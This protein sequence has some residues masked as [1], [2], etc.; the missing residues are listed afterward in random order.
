MAVGVLNAALDYAARGWHV[1]PLHGVVGGKCSCGKTNCNRSAG[2]HPQ[3]T[4]W[5]KKASID[6]ETIAGW[7]EKWPDA[8]I[9]VQLG[10][11]SGIIDIEYDT[12]QGQ[13]TAARLFSDCFTPSYSSGGRSTHRLFRWTSDLPNIQKI[14][15]EGLEIRIGGG[16]KGTQSVFP[17]SVHHSGSIYT[18]LPGLSPDDVDVLPIPD[19]VVALFAN[20][21]QT[22]GAGGAFTAHDKE[23]WERIGRGVSEGSRNDSLASWIGKQL[24][25]IKTE[26]LEKSESVQNV[27]RSAFAVN[28]KFEPPLEQDEVRQVFASILRRERQ[29]RITTEIESQVQPSVDEQVAKQPPRG[30]AG[31][32]KIVVIE[33]DP[34]RFE[35]HAPEFIKA[36]DGK[37]ILTSDQICNGGRIRVQA[38]EQASYALSRSFSKAWDTRLRPNEPSLYERLMSAAEHIEA[39]PEEKRFLFLA[40]M[41][42]EFIQSPKQIE[43]GDEPEKLRPCQLPNGD[44]VFLFSKLVSRM[45][46]TDLVTRP[47]VSSV[48]KRVEAGWHRHGKTRF[49]KL[50]SESQKLLQN[51]LA[52]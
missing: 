18:W 23:H 22:L 40:E 29:Q 35:L 9:G 24:S 41:I 15:A 25:D 50:S 39:P 7:F 44:I 42:A 38:A 16:D 13:K 12:P 20:D 21:P 37:L 45:K 48:L 31:T 28:E 34:K 14:E 33:S 43:E 11:R 30:R 19:S 47:E 3:F 49:K 2:K 6:E 32:W 36:M 5:Q 17:P 10:P 52:N 1:V 26:A 27:L 8:N 4:E 46:V 51:L